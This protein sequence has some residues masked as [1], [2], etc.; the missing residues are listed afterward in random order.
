MVF[1]FS[2]IILFLIFYNLEHPADLLR[3]SIS[4]AISFDSKCLLNFHVSAPYVTLLLTIELYIS[5]L[6][7]I[8]I[9]IILI[10]IIIIIIMEVQLLCFKKFN[11]PRV[12]HTSTAVTIWLVQTYRQ[13]YA[14]CLCTEVLGSWV[15]TVFCAR[16]LLC[17]TLYLYYLH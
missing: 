13:K 6:L 15:C 9:I 10:I 1:I 14:V 5:N 7:L 4:I 3:M 2:L 12:I 17:S 11:I 16:D 8:I